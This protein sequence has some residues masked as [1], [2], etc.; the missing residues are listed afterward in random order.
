MGIEDDSDRHNLYLQKLA[1]GI[2]NSDVY[3]SLEAARLAARALLLDAEELRSISQVKKLN[4]AIAREVNTIYGAGWDDATVSLE[5]T[6]YYEAE[7]QAAAI[8]AYT[9]E[10]L[11]VPPYAR[12]KSYIDRSIMSLHSGQKINAGVWAD[13]VRGN[14]SS[15]VQQYN[16]SVINGF[17]NG[18][19]VNQIARDIKQVTDGV[20]STQA[21]TLA[22]TGM[23]HYANGA[24]DVMA[25]DNSDI[26]KKR[27]FS[28]T[29]DNRTTLI[30]RGNDGKAWDMSDKTYPRLPLH[31]GERSSYYFVTDDS[32][33]G[34]G[35][36]AAVGGKT[37]GSDINPRRKLKYRGK[38][39]K[40][41]FTPGQ[42]NAS[43]TQDAWLRRQ[44]RWLVES[45]LGKTKAKLFLDGG[46]KIDKFTDMQGKTINLDQLR[47]LDANAFEKAGI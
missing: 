39:D 42:I 26:I 14:K 17:Q 9:S 5:D 18:L 16:A 27:V 10:T 24:R 3:P 8:G 43:T 46:L 6:A 40:D 45:T 25:E 19:T 22:R 15:V 12:I 44:P 7:W 37:D 41:I 38:K 20:L 28:A 13:F 2:Y 34:Q 11:K 33:I 31:F 30:C 35:R 36:K 1:A 21:E 29:F 47:K 4:A 23:A 32:E